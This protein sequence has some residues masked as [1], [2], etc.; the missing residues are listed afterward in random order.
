MNWSAQFTGFRTLIVN[1]V[2]FLVLVGTAL[3][4]QIEDGTTLRYIAIAITIGNVALRFLTNGPVGKAEKPID[5][6]PN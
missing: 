3:T 6:P 5:L 4:G 2:M 1:T